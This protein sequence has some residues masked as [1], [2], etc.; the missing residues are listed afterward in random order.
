MANQGFEKTLLNVPGIP[1]LLMGL[2]G[3]VLWRLRAARKRRTGQVHDKR[4]HH[5]TSH[6]PVMPNTDAN[7]L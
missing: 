3:V 2:T 5:I 6:K 1:L 7:A 4:A